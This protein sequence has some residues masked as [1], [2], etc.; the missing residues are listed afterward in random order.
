MHVVG[1]EQGITLPGLTLVCS[2][3]HTAT[4]GALGALAF[5][6][7]ASEVA[8]VLA[9]QTLW[10][11]RPRRMRIGIEGRLGPHVS[12]KDLILAVIAEIGAAG[13]VGHAIEFAGPAVCALS[14]PS[15]APWVSLTLLSM[16]SAMVVC[17]RR[18]CTR[19]IQAPDRSVRTARLAT[20]VSHMVSKRPIWLVE[21]AVRPAVGQRPQ[22]RW[23]A[24]GAG[25]G[26]GTLSAPSKRRFFRGDAGYAN[27]DIYEFLEAEGYKYTIRLPA[28]AVL[29][30]SI[31][32]LL[33]RPVGVRRTR[34]GATTPVSATGP[35]RGA[36]PAVWWPRSS[37]IL[38]NCIRAS[39]SS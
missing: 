24:P 29:Q 11:R 34:C 38:A 17:G 25:A 22:R 30:E 19:S 35:D 39:G 37:G 1:P 27:P 3:S 15:C 32:R 21:A 31:G 36:E 7:G 26:G 4:Q 28:N 20:L 8:H 9:T 13:A 10:Q 5:G 2:D 12:A 33:K 16:S 6:I 14:V 23:R 18:A